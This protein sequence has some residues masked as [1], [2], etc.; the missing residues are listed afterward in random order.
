MLFMKDYSFLLEI[1]G[2][3]LISKEKR[4][5]ES[6]PLFDENFSLKQDQLLTFRT[7]YSLNKVLAHIGGLGAVISIL[8]RS[9]FY[10]FKFI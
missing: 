7:C 5:S 3:N 8:F 9:L 4:D 10:K 2:D 1:V 6:L